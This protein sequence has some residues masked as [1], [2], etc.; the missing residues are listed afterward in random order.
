VCPQITH[1]TLLR[2]PDDPNKLRGYAFVHFTERSMALRVLTD[3][4]SD[5][6]FEMDDKQLAINMARPQVSVPLSL[7]VCV[8]REEGGRREVLV[9]VAVQMVSGCGL[10]A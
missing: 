7:S 1:V 10:Q 9:M 5:K 6:E 4:E 2:Q 3:A 8:S